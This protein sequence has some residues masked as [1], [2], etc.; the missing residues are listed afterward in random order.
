[1]VEDAEFHT[2]PD[3]SRIAAKAKSGGTILRRGKIEKRSINFVMAC[4]RKLR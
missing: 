2:S 1:M 4:A 3:I